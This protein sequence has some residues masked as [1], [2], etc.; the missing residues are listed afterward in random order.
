MGGGEG[1][2]NASAVKKVGSKRR[3]QERR[4]A[5]GWLIQKESCC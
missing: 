1:G 5:H 3:S 4:L 2:T